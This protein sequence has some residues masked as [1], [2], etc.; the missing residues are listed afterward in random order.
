MV[1]EANYI[2]ST[3]KIKVEY[4]IKNLESEL[5]KTSYIVYN[6]LTIFNILN[7]KI[8][9]EIKDDFLIKRFLINKNII[10]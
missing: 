4:N 9:K 5:F 2:G 6:K 8:Y 7:N 1:Y 10:F 3:I